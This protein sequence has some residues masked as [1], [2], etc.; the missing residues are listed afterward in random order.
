MGEHEA[1]GKLG[2][3]CTLRS[4]P[5]TYVRRHHTSPLDQLVDAQRKRE[6]AEDDEHVVEL[7][8]DGGLWLVGGSRWGQNDQLR[9]CERVG[10]WGGGRSGWGGYTGLTSLKTALTTSDTISTI[11]TN[12]IVRWL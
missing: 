7:Q 9:K 4:P 11:S 1:S 2:V 5:G 3:V 6:G 8:R 10:E 12:D